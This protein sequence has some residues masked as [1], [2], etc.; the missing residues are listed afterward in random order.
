MSKLIA[1]PNS[2]RTTFLETSQ[3]LDFRYQKAALRGD[4]LPSSP[5]DEVDF[6]YICFVKSSDGVIY[7][8]DGDA[9]GP[10]KTDF[11]LDENEDMFET[12]ALECVKQCIAR[13][14][15]DGKFSLL[16]IVPMN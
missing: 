7:E 8:L 10:S 9:S 12:S 15:A 5:Q 14:H 6:H 13:E 3:D 11:R 1:C 2:A 4:T 16:A